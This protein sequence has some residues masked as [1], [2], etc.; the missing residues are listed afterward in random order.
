M[1]STGTTQA[2]AGQN[3]KVLLLMP[4]EVPMYWEAALPLLERGYDSL[5]VLPEDLL[6]MLLRGS[7]NLWLA[8]NEDEPVLAMVTTFI[9]Y[10]RR[11]TLHVMA[12]GGKEFI[13]AGHLFWPKVQDF[14]VRNECA[15]C[16]AFCRDGMS[17]ILR[18]NFGFKKRY[19]M[20]EKTIN[21]ALQ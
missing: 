12:L 19:D 6:E 8:L 4:H 20:V 10:P 14:M 15:V 11:K 13:A 17:Y 1:E 21:G 16:T 9:H 5:E 3:Y 18:N 7:G 2:A